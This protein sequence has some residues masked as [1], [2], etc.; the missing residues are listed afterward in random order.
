MPTATY[1]RAA[2]RANSST[3][4]G[5]RVAASPSEPGHCDIVPAVS[6]TPNCAT[7]ERWWRGFVTK[8]AGRPRREPSATA[9]T[10][11]SHVAIVFGSAFARLMNWR[12]CRRRIA[13]DVPGA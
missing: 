10:A 9:C 5:S 8:K 3:R 11:F 4:A 2:M 7:P 1:S 6:F 13:S 12:M